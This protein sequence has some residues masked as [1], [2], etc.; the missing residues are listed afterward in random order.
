MYN[1]NI[2]HLFKIKA[3]ERSN[4]IKIYIWRL[5]LLNN[6]YLITI[7]LSYIIFNLILLKL[8]KQ[9]KFKFFYIC[10]I[11]NF[12]KRLS[13]SLKLFVFHQLIQIHTDFE[14]QTERS[15]SMWMT[16]GGCSLTLRATLS[17]FV[18]C[19]FGT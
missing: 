11:L 14:N 10:Y 6:K 4:M 12:L 1:K 9:S 8:I 2:F 5:I 16:K 7:S 3:S 17:T 19:V 13:K 18:V 15:W